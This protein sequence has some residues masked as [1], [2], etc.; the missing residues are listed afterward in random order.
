MTPEQDQYHEITTRFADQVVEA[1]E[2]GDKEKALSLIPALTRE[3]RNM[4]RLL[5]QVISQFL[6]PF[7]E[8]RFIADQKKTGEE[9]RQAIASGETEKAIELT[10]AKTERWLRLH[11]T[12]IDFMG[13]TFGWINDNLG[14][15]ALF[16]MYRR[17]GD[18]TKDWFVKRS[19]VPR[20]EIME[21]GAIMWREH[22]GKTRV[23]VQ[24]GRSLFYLEP[25]GSGGRRLERIR[26]EQAGREGIPVRMKEPFPLTV[27][28][29]KDVPTYCTHCPYLFEVLSREWTGAPVWVVNPPQKVGDP[30]I[31]EV[32]DDK[33]Y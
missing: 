31:I 13:D 23:E 32:R 30:C 4:E 28:E 5:A 9:I 19:T 22:I 33:K 7:L 6:V 11:D 17:W 8:E 3:D 1:L 2:Q 24:D 18:G 14:Q 15:Q 20:Q 10:R 25:C 29:R 26:D 16:D 21:L 12:Y 27:G